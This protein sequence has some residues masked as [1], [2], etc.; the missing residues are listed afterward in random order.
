MKRNRWYFFFLLLLVCRFVSGQEADV[1]IFSPSD[2]QKA[3]TGH[4]LGYDFI[5]L[6]VR[7]DMEV[8]GGII[9]TE[10]CKP[11]H[12]S[13]NFDD[14]QNNY[15]L[16]PTDVR[17]IIYCRSGNRSLQAGLFLVGKGFE[18]V[19]SVAGGINQYHGELEDSTEFKLWKEFPDPSYHGSVGV[20][21]EG[22][23]A[24]VLPG[25]QTGDENRRDVF[26]LQGRVIKEISGRK[27]TGILII[28]TGDTKTGMIDGLLPLNRKR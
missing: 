4:T 13:W 8:E 19:G 20:R 16:L 5:L 25:I 3:I 2:L 6:D 27:S 7:D 11:Y 23:R 18:L 22:R 17:V 15:S 21:Y 12:M 9:A 28:Q 14:L 26:T 24:P 1:V 10:Y